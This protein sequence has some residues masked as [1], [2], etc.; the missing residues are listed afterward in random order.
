MVDT[1]MPLKKPGKKIRNTLC[2]IKR[3]DVDPKNLQS[4]TSFLNI[5]E[6][7]IDDY[8]YIC[9]QISLWN[10]YGISHSCGNFI[11]KFFNNILGTNARIFHFVPN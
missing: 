10:T 8:S 11:F 3:K 5:T 7:R 6:I 1:Y 2:K 4:I 9:K